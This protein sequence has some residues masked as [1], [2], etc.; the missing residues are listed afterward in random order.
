MPRLV[1]AARAAIACA[2]ILALSS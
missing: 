1:F 2:P